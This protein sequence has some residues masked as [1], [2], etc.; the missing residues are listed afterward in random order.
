[1]SGDGPLKILVAD[2]DRI[3]LRLME[4]M[5]KR[6]GYD[7]CTA[8]DGLQAASML[9]AE[10]G[11]RLALIDWMMPGL[12][13]PSVCREVRKRQ[14]G[15]YVYIMLLTSKQLSEDVV[16]GLQAGADDYLT[17]PCNPA[18]LE[19][20]LR[21]GQRILRLEDNLGRVRTNGELR[22]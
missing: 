8:E 15:S 12:D 20:R 10:G 13:G 2:D 18:E 7:V 22:R 19:A 16:N 4:R 1:M 11:P 9:C 17:K 3:S 14:D 6:N 5:L 21:S